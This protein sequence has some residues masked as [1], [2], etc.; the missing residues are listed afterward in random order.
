MTLTPRAAAGRTRIA[1]V[2]LAVTALAS[3]AAEP[4]ETGSTSSVP[5]SSAPPSSGVA[6][7]LPT[8]S[9]AVPATCEDMTE[10][11]FDAYTTDSPV[12][13]VNVEGPDPA[14]A[15]DGVPFPELLELLVDARGAR[16]VYILQD[17]E[18]GEGGL[19]GSGRVFTVA[20]VSTEERAAL[21]D[22]LEADGFSSSDVDGR[23]VYAI[24]GSQQGE[25][26]PT[27]VHVVSDGVWISGSE[28]LGP[29]LEEM[30]GTIDMI[31][32]NVGAW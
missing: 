2:V 13:A 25:Y 30:L 17:R 15:E 3:C 29:S 7:P 6:T 12:A 23:A 24:V 28:N 14:S 31:A 26:D 27:T 19:D 4:A 5:A 21:V 32:E 20:A 18:A 8:S 1:L 22:R 9:F 11:L 16:C 10:G